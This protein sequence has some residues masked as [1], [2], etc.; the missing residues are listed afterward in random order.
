LRLAIAA[1][2][3]GSIVGVAVPSLPSAAASPTLALDPSLAFAGAAVR[4][5]G[6]NLPPHARLQLA[7]DGGTLT[8]ATLESSAAGTLR[9]R[10]IIP[11]SAPGAHHLAAIP[12]AGQPGLDATLPLAIADFVVAE[13]D[14]AT[15]SLS[16]VDPESGLIVPGT[17]ETPDATRAPATPAPRATAKPAPKPAPKPTP[18]PHSSSPWSVPFLARTPSGPI[19]ISNRSNVVISGKEFVNLGSDVEAI[20]IE[21]SHNITIR[22]NDFK[23]VA[24]GITVYN[25][26]NVVIEWNR[27]QNILGP[28]ER[29]G[30]N[31]GNFTQWVNSRGG[32][33]RN[34]KGIGGDTEDIISIYE[35]GGTSGAPLMISGNHFEGTNWSST[36][37]SGMM[38]GD[39]GGSYITVS[40]NTLVTPG[41]VGIGVPGGSHIR[42]INNVIYGARHASSNVGI[43]VWNQSS[44]A[45][46]SVEVSGNKVRFYRSDGVENPAWDGGGCGGVAGWDNNNWHASLSLS[47]LHVRL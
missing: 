4:L 28:H 2:L 3:V 41:Q 14:E 31:R 43:Y 17:S 47:S 34:N 18:R 11:S 44:A 46:S 42:I 20:R 26:T 19:R 30:S 15:P 29:D 33:I 5:R 23:N 25:S 21:N 38:L 12:L 40:G 45:C 37:G 7:W 36:S 8:S 22:A 9:A 13:P 6:D 32:A 39:A 35:S 27:Y 24:Q 1:V 10:F 16:G